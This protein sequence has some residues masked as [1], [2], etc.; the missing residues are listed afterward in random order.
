MPKKVREALRERSSG[1]P[2]I[3]LCEL[4]GKPANNAHHRKNRSQG[5]RDVLSNL[6]LLCGS[7]TT[8]CHGWIT[9]YPR[10][11]AER[12][13]TVLSFEDSATKPVYL[14]YRGE[15]LLGDDGSKVAA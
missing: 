14:A 13:W 2:D 1:D 9:N 10:T 11:S 4:C 7:G 8:G 12:G 5:G 6:L 3:G 15:F